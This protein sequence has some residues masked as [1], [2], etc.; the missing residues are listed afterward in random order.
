[1]G[2]T[3]GGGSSS[4]NPW[5]YQ[6]GS[7]WRNIPDHVKRINFSSVPQEFV[8]SSL[9]GG[10]QQWL[11]ADIPPPWVHTR[12][13]GGPYRSQTQ[14]M[15][16]L[17]KAQREQNPQWPQFAYE[18]QQEEAER[19]RKQREAIDAKNKE[20]VVYAG[21]VVEGE[22]GAKKKKRGGGPTIVTSSGGL[23]SQ[24]T[25]VQPTLIGS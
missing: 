10:S 2:P 14:A 9:K 21:N 4:T 7:S 5:M 18:R 6:Y 19:K 20:A 11:M 15:K 1:M 25:T 22:E 16:E 17:K 3:G 23:L 13:G 8:G 24:A 12:H